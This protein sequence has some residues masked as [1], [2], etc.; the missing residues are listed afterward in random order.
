[1]NTKEILQKLQAVFQ[2]KVE[3]TQLSEIEVQLDEVQEEVV[4]QV[5][6]ADAPK[7][8]VAP[9]VEAEPAPTME[10]A[11]KLEL[12]EMKRT[13]L[14]LLAALQKET[15]GK[16][17]VP[18]ELSSD[19]EVELAENV[20]EISHSPELEVEKKLELKYG[21]KNLNSIQSRIY[22]TLFN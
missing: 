5:E 13:F 11:T 8:D 14:E 21:N 9:A 22:S 7:E 6:L 20:D 10:Y 2:P 3:E 1:M 17:E 15:E 19:V 12:E 4:E 16:Q 18:Q